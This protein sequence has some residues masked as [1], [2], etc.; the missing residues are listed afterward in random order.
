[1]KLKKKLS[2]DMVTFI[3]DVQFEDMDNRRLAKA[4]QITVRLRLASR[5]QKDNYMQ[6]SHGVGASEG[7]LFI[8][9]DYQLA[10]ER[11]V[12]EVCNLEFEGSPEKI[13]GPKLFELQ[14]Q[15]PELSSLVDECF[16]KICGTHPDDKKKVAI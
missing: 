5:K 1:M 11:N 12:I 2:N 13:D 7:R 10:I 4:E 6:L 14:E 3:P 16:M 8:D 9:M 15:Y